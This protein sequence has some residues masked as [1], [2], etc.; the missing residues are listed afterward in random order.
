MNN[1]PTV[2]TQK[3]HGVATSNAVFLWVNYALK[4]NVTPK[5]GLNYQKPIHV[6]NYS[7]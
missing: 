7:F 6:F 4:C 5:K 3:K 1:I 2:V